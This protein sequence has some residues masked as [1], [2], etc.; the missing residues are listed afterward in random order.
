[1]TFAG[2][3]KVKRC[4]SSS[5]WVVHARDHIVFGTEKIARVCDDKRVVSC[6]TT[7]TPLPGLEGDLDLSVTLGSIR[8]T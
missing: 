2:R 8:F 4:H 3:R 5:V 1:M 7:R 6:Q